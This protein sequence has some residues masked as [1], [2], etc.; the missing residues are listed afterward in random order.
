M[1][2]VHAIVG[3]GGWAVM[4]LAAVW[5]TV[6]AVVLTISA[7]ARNRRGLTKTEVV[8]LWWDQSPA[9]SAAGRPEGSQIRT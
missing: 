6:G 1:I 5:L 2:I 7:R 9:P 8:P 4:L 3:F